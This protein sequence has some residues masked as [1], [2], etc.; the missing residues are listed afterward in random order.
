MCVHILRTLQIEVPDNQLE[1]RN[2]CEI[3]CFVL[4]GFAFYSI[5][6]YL[7]T[8]GLKMGISRKM[9]HFYPVNSDAPYHSKLMN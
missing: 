2:I 5:L 7:K 3:L 4:M 1:L 8:S 9:Y 6:R